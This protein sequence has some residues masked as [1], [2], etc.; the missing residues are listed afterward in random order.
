M[1]VELEAFLS[2]VPVDPLDPGIGEPL[3]RQ[4]GQHLT[5]QSAFAGRTTIFHSGR[6]YVALLPA[7]RGYEGL[8]GSRTTKV[9]PAFSDDVTAI[10][11]L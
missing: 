7:L 9:V 3:S 10:V 6:S 11:P 5:Q 2:L 1:L 8:R 4:E